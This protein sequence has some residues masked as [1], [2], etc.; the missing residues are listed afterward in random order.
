MTE[1]L[2]K[3]TRRTEKS[4]SGFVSDALLDR[5]TID[6][7][8]PAFQEMSLSSV[9]FQCILSAADAEALEASGS[10]A[11][12]KNVPFI[13]ELFRSYGHELSFQE[14]VT[15][16]LGK[17]SGWFSIEGDPR[18][19]GGWMT[20]RHGC[21]MKWSRFLRAYLL[22]AHNAFSEE[23]LEVKVGE[24]FVEINLEQQ[25]GA[26]PVESVRLEELESVS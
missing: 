1:R 18:L 9:T 21:D 2:D 20:L 10:Y 22:T 13:R 17:H 25:E 16:V 5:L 14:F 4:E 19:N 8:I 7:L 23:N 12:Q 15:N 24:Q 3:A 11:A 6:P 26:H